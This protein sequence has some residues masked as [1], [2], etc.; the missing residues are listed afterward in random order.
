MNDI[1]IT[2][3]IKAKMMIIRSN[4]YSKL[5][6]IKLLII[7]NIAELVLLIGLFFIIQA[8][9]LVNEILGMYIVGFILTGLS[10]FMLVFP[11]K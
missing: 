5:N 11:K 2:D 10:I 6:K 8:S 7:Q 4:I 1:K 3:R 9:F